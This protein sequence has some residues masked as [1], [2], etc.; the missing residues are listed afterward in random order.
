MQIFSNTSGI[1]IQIK[2]KSKSDKSNSF[3]YFKEKTMRKKNTGGKRLIV[4]FDLV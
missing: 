1:K 3:E 4:T 2:N